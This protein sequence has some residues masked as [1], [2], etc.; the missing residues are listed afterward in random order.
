[1]EGWD[2]ILFLLALGWAAVG[3]VALQSTVGAPSIV[4]PPRYALG[5]VAT[6]HVIG[7]LLFPIS[8]PI[9]AAVLTAAEVGIVL[10]FFLNFYMIEKYMTPLRGQLEE[11]LSKGGP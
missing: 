11:I 7:F 6:L 5:G 10:Y 9:G 4:K 8:T 1:M 2:W 3:A